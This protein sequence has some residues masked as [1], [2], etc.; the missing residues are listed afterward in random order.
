MTRHLYGIAAVLMALLT[1]FA[2][3]S[4]Q[5]G[6]PLRFCAAQHNLPLS[7][8]HPSAGIE[9]EVARAIAQRLGREPEFVWREVDEEGLE[10]GVREGACDAALGV[11]VETGGI[12]GSPA[13]PGI[14]RTQPYYGAGY[15]L[16]HRSGTRPVQ[17]LAELQGTRIAVEAESVPIYTLKQRGQPIHALFNHGAVIEAVAAGRVDYGYLWGPITAR[18]LGGRTDV[19]IAS[20]FQPEDRWN[21]ALAVQ[22]ND[23]ELH[24]QLNEAVAA[25]VREGVVADIFARAGVPYLV[26]EPQPTRRARTAGAG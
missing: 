16:I 26:P 13:L 6:T 18:L 8:A 10:E 7:A 17:T 19:V 1:A 22:E 5:T 25:L 11:M 4:A 24:A 14:A 23:S 12:A 21:F 2:D 3:S 20:D 9:L 15:V